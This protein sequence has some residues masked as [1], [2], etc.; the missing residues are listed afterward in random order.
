VTG[1]VAGRVGFA[2]WDAKPKVDVAFASNLVLY[3]YDAHDA[4]GLN[5]ASCS[6]FLIAHRLLRKTGTHFFARC[7]RLAEPDLLCAGEEKMAGSDSDSK[8]PTPGFGS[9]GVSAASKTLQ[10]FIEELSQ[11]TQKNLE[12]TTKVMEDLRGARN[13]GDLL[14]IQSK[15]VQQTFDAFNERLRRM[16]VLM[17]EL[18]AEFAQ[19]Q[20]NMA[21]A[22]N[23]AAQNA[24]KAVSKTISAVS[25]ATGETPPH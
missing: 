9:A 24:A 22:G 8:W 13:M 14:S 20:K 25:N 11:L 5:E 21:E 2:P 18:P 17:A 16:S 7:A 19:V 12:Q 4:F 6:R 23:E 1:A 3:F 10:V 15:F